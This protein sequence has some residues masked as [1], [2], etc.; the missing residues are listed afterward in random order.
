MEPREEN[1]A[2]APAELG[3]TIRDLCVS[4]DG[5]ELLENAACEFPAGKVSLVVGASGAGKTVLMK[6]LTGLIRPGER[7]F[8]IEGSIRIGD[9]E[10]LGGRGKSRVGIVFQNFALFDEFS[11]AGNIDFAADHRRHRV[12]KDAG[13]DSR[14]LLREFQIPARTPVRALSGGQ[15]Q[16]L[17]IART[18]AYDP[19]V[20][21][22]DEPTSGLDPVNARK[23]AERIRST[24]EVHGKTTIVV[25]HDYEHLARIADA[26]YL[27]DPEKRS[28]E[29]LSDDA[30]DDL[31]SNLPGAQVFE[32]GTGET[33]PPGWLRA[34]RSTR[35]FLEHTG[36][37][38]ER[39]PVTLAHLVPWWRSPLWGFRF[40]LHYIALIASFSSWIYFAAAGLVAGFV[41]TY[42]PFTFL[43]HKR[44]TEALIADELL[45]GLGY[46]LYR[47][48]V[49]VLVTVLVA[50]RCGAAVASDV[51]NRS[52]SRQVDALRSFG[53]R[54]SKYLLT[55]ILFAFLVGT[56]FVVGVGW[57]TA[58]FTSLLVFAFNRPEKGPLF[59]ENHFHRDLIV[60]GELLYHGSWWLL[61]K[62]L[63]CGLGVGSIAYHVAIRPK[64]SGVE[65]SRG[66]TRTIIWATLYV[67]AVHFGFA[68]LEFEETT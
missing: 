29:K 24:G 33:V 60:P 55:N 27:L 67:L 58:R 4:V 37:A 59:W 46:L 23:V 6:I 49:P 14:S 11:C 62:I 8:A 47:V 66:I 41:S 56:P 63:L 42:F 65:V 15:Q 9:E 22:Y 68:F 13:L 3:I 16:R 25:T 43:P 19:P 39:V 54:P 34:L 26:V 48:V 50:A 20:I 1:T 57:L 53:A 64:S 10:V 7:P 28:L 40:F 44:Y 21:I 36:A 32:E 18:L 61:A 2:D 5:K 52:W 12:A 31:S 38:L 51:G 35:S 45:N 30:L 17:A